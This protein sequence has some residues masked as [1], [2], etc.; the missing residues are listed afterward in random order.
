MYNTNQARVM[1]TSER[2]ALA[3]EFRDELEDEHEQRLH[4]LA[5]RRQA[6]RDRGHSRNRED[7][8]A[9]ANE[10]RA[11]VRR[12]FYAE[13]GYRR[14]IDSG[15]RELWLA[16]EEY[17]WRMRVRKRR[18]RNRN[19]YRPSIWVRRRMLMVYGLLVVVAIGVGIVLIN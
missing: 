5:E 3:N 1:D 14:Y 4:A 7:A 19:L 2:E 8:I 9:E 16:P 10:L 12:E 6:A 13:K 11:T 15:G 17:E 18:D